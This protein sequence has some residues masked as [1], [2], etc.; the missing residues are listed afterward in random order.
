MLYNCQELF[1]SRHQ[2]KWKQDSTPLYR[3]VGMSARKKHHWPFGENECAIACPNLILSQEENLSYHQKEGRARST[4]RDISEIH[5]K[6][7]KGKY[8]QVK[9]IES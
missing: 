1:Y 6:S 4:H 7:S 5:R 2:H 8:L 9:H 3:N